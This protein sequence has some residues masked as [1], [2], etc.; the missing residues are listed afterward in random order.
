V[1]ATKSWGPTP[2]GTV[3]TEVDYQVAAPLKR[4]HPP[5]TER[6]SLNKECGWKDGNKDGPAQTQNPLVRN[7][8]TDWTL[9]GL[10]M[11][12]LGLFT[13]VLEGPAAVASSLCRERGKRT[14]CKSN[15]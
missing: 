3:G 9:T 14:M 12:G 4:E 13:V 8:K 2:T 11:E 1:T 5:C 10:L 7:R 15:V 6:Q